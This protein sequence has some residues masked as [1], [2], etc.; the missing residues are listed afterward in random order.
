VARD[1]ITPV[2]G[3]M[4]GQIAE[5]AGTTIVV[6]NGGN[7]ALPAGAVGVT[8][9]LIIRVDNTFAGAKIFTIRAGI[10]PPAFRASMGDLAISILSSSKAYFFIEAA[11]FLQAD[12]SI[13]V[14]YEAA[15]TGTVYAILVPPEFVG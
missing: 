4:N 6:A 11:R 2:V 8:D 9:R 7:I 12:G 3:V 5:G 1:A 14:D 10:Y 15:M 13:N